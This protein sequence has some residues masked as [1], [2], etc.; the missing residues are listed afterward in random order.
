MQT[1][2][3]DVEAIWD[4]VK[5]YV[6]TGEIKGKNKREL[7]KSIK[8]AFKKAERGKDRRGNV[9]NL[10]HLANSFAESERVQKD[11]NYYPSE[12]PVE[13]PV[14]KER[15]IK[16]LSVFD[17]A[18]KKGFFKQAKGERITLKIAG[19]SKTFVKTNVKISRG[20]KRLTFSNLRTKRVLTWR[21]IFNE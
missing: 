15:A 19:R 6:P 3:Y 17:L 2:A 8:S 4:R 7:A 21:K 20:E 1:G 13:K 18:L 11:L 5:K 10:L 12:K 16:P 14:F 9:K